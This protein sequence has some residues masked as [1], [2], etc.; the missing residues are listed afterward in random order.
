MT[1]QTEGKPFAELGTDHIRIERELDQRR[2]GLS[3]LRLQAAL[4][5]KARGRAALIFVVLVFGFFG[6]FT[7]ELLSTG[8]NAVTNDLVL[9]VM[10]AVFFSVVWLATN[11]DN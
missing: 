11:S 10:I 3:A 7:N 9:L 6:L 1:D 5:V 8:T 2:G 4:W